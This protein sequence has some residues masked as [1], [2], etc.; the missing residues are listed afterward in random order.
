LCRIT[1]TDGEKYKHYRTAVVPLIAKFGGEIVVQRGTVELLE[2]NH[3]RAANGHVEF[4]SMEALHA[5]WNSP[6][7]VP[8]KELRRVAANLDIW[9]SR[10]FDG[11]AI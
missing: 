11:S 10:E 7:Y 9:L 2:G 3:E 5:F 6:E 4:P 1:I 8:V